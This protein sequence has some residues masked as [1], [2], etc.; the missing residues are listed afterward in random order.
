MAG[1]PAAVTGRG[2]PLLARGGSWH[3]TSQERPITL[4][5]LRQ[6][7]APDPRPQ[8]PSAMGRSDLTLFLLPLAFLHGGV[9]VQGDTPPQ[10][11]QR[12]RVLQVPRHVHRPEQERENQEGEPSVPH[13]EGHPLPPQAVTIRALPEPRRAPGEGSAQGHLG[14][15]SSDGHVECKS[16]CTIFKLII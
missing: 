7:G 2:V 15:L 13:H 8:G 3:L 4:V 6:R 11:L 14:A 12:L 10:Q 9:Q 5:G 16:R 1:A